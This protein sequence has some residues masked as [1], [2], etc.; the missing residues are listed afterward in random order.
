MVYQ[1]WCP[2]WESKWSAFKARTAGRTRAE[3]IHQRR[4]VAEEASMSFCSLATD[5]PIGLPS[6]Q[7]TF[8]SWLCCPSS[9]CVLCSLCCVVSIQEPCPIPKEGKITCSYEIGLCL[10]KRI[11]GLRCDH[12][13]PCQDMMSP[14]RLLEKILRES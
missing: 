7:T 1:R 6:G 9:Y 10:F 13:G 12:Q 14:P 2:C 11:L 4:E 8:P 5:R 3:D